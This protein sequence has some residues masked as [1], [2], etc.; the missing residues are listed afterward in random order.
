MSGL[1]VG[2]GVC[3]L[4]AVAGTA[5]LVEEGRKHPRRTDRYW[6]ET[7]SEALDRKD[8]RI[9]ELERT[10]E[11]EEERRQF[12]ME[13]L[14]AEQLAISVRNLRDGDRLPADEGGRD[15]ARCLDSYLNHRGELSLDVGRGES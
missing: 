13:R 12:W 8:V 1:L 5:Y 3:F 9:E 11:T 15:V 10:Q 2:A 7:F 14:K 6:Q 4:L